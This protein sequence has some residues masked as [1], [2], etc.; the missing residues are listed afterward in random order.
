MRTAAQETAHLLP[1][2]LGVGRSI[3]VI[4]VRG[5]LRN[6]HFKLASYKFNLLKFKDAPLVQTHL[7]QTTTQPDPKQPLDQRSNVLKMWS[8][9]FPSNREEN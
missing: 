1:K 6:L 7:P 8:Q 9:L 3:Y 4:L 5:E 2:R